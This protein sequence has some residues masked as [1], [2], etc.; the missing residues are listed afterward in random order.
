[1]TRSRHDSNRELIAQGSGNI[2]SAC[3]GGMPGA[4]Q[5][6]ATLV[7]LTSGGQTRISGV[8]EGVLSLITFPRPGKPH[9]LDSGRLPG[10]HPDHRRRAHD[11]PHSLHLL[12]SP[13]T[14]FDFFVVLTVVAV[15]LSATA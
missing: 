5:M 4:G 1:M 6:G 13:W 10:G 15:A 8:I 14:R 3:V 7:N 11:R 2:A 9:C 12:D